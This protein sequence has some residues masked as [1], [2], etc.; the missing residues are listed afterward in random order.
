VNRR[1]RSCVSLVAA[2][3]AVCLGHQALWA[4]DEVDA[5]RL[6]LTGRVLVEPVDARRV[7]VAI[8]TRMD[9]SA[10]HLFLYTASK[11]LLA[12]PH[13]GDFLGTIYYETAGGLRIIP[14]AGDR[15]TLE[16]VVGKAFAAQGA[17][18]AVMRFTDTL[19]LAHYLADPR[20]HLESLKTLHRAADCNREPKACVDVAGQFLPFPG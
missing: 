19:G 2:L 7:L 9:G 5:Q 15:Q 3:A 6:T 8:A 17:G 10:E 13:P 11:P 14:A 16:F 1:R 4:G 12:P 18:G 20:L